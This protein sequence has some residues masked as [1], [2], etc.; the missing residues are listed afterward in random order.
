MNQEALIAK[1]QLVIQNKDIELSAKDDQISKLNSKISKITKELYQMKKKYRQSLS[2]QTEYSVSPK[3]SSN[4]E[5]LVKLQEA[6]VVLYKDNVQLQNQNDLFKKCLVAIDTCLNP[7]EMDR[8]D[9][10]ALLNRVENSIF[11][12]SFELNE[13]IQFNKQLLSSATTDVEALLNTNLEPFL[14]K[15]AVIQQENK[16]LKLQIE[17][18]HN[19]IK[20]VTHQNEILGKAANDLETVLQDKD[21]SDINKILKKESK[22][23]IF[24]QQMNALRRELLTTEFKIE[25]KH[26]VQPLDQHFL[27]NAF[28]LINNQKLELAELTLK[29]NY[30]KERVQQQE[31]LFRKYHLSESAD[32]SNNNIVGL[33]GSPAIQHFIAKDEDFK[34]LMASHKSL[35]EHIMECPREP[36]TIPF[37]TYK[38]G[39][40]QIQRQEE[41]INKN[42]KLLDRTRKAFGKKAYQ[43][44]Q[45]TFNILGWHLDLMENNRFKVMNEDGRYFIFSG[46]LDKLVMVGMGPDAYETLEP[47]VQEW[48]TEKKSFSGF[49]ATILLLNK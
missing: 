24:T 12:K 26:P 48:L 46:Q 21:D 18:Q 16:E 8:S 19:E 43:V 3:P 25:C 20:F 36:A 13:L 49:L 38:K 35:L 6:T 10:V 39:Q 22:Y 9:T 5:E 11:N 37:E 45:L 15:Y 23:A 40:L 32:A 17:K 14:A 34:Q 1:Y 42:C 4:D 28:K 27:N 47:F 33:V 31:T 30:L 41:E 7:D 2:N 29:Y 44:K